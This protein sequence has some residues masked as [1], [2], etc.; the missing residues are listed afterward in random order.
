M[1]NGF[2]A[3]EELDPLFSVED[4]EPEGRSTLL[5]GSKGGDHRP[6]PKIGGGNPRKEPWRAKPG[7][8]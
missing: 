8:G 7:S 3:A 4:Q 5:Q 6:D 2:N 1:G